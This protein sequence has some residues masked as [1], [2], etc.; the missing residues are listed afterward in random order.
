[1]ALPKGQ[2]NYGIKAPIRFIQV[3]IKKMLNKQI[4]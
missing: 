3:L 2:Y 1:M 4:K